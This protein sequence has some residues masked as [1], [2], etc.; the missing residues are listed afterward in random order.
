[1]RRSARRLR[2]ARDRDPAAPS[3]EEFLALAF[4][5]VAEHFVEEDRGGAAGENRGAVEGFGDRSFAQ[6]LETLAQI[7]YGGF[8]V[9]LIGKPVDGF[10]FEG[11]F[12]KEIHAIVGA[13][14]G[15]GHEAREQM[16]RDDLRAFG[17]R[18][19]IGLVLRP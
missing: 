16:G 19:I 8:E 15:N 11:L 10:S 3:H 6:R 4:E 7:A 5:P 13:R 1:M 18:E 9:G 17:R 2:E 12:A 14:D